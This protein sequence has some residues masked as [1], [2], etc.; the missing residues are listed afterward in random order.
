LQPKSQSLLS[1]YLVIFL[2]G[3]STGLLTP[4]FPLYIRSLGITIQD[5]GSLVMTYAISTFIFEWAWGVL[6]DRTDRR[7]FIAAGLL[8]GALLIFLYTVSNSVQ[9]FY[10][11]QFFRGALFIMVGPAV[12]ALV[13][14]LSSSRKLGLSMG[15]YSATRTLGG[16]VGP[17]LG[18]SI[19]QFY[20]YQHALYAY[21]I[22]SLTGALMTLAISKNN[23]TKTNAGSSAQKQ[24][25]KQLFTQKN[26]AILFLSPIIIFMGNT[27]INSYIPLYASETIGMSTLEIGALFTAASISGFI[28]TPIF[29]WISDRTGRKPVIFSGFLLSA[30]MFSGLFF[31]G[32]PAYLALALIALK[33]CFLPM[34]PLLLA[35][36][37][38]TT[39]QRLLGTSMGI[40]STFENLG[41]VIAPPIYTAI[42]TI[43]TPALIFPF[44]GLMMLVGLTPLVL[45]RKAGSAS[46]GTQS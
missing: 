43:Y 38:E 31:A 41:T 30:A 23:T 42:W 17:I 21:S 15:L 14:Q 19:A 5:W 40:Y 2:W 32:T 46:S 16:V 1:F 4:V 9:L 3:T 35:M 25:W 13:S 27:T 44:S 10:I 22:T 11:L 26:I 45:R 29:G 12:K 18:S 34:T 7:L 39:P 33:M 6:S 28:A 24:E 8:S 36:L 37:S 20:S